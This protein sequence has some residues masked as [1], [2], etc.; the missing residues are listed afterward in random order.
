[1][2]ADDD[3]EDEEEDEEEEEENGYVGGPVDP[4]DPTM[5]EFERQFLNSLESHG[6]V[7]HHVSGTDPDFGQW[8]SGFLECLYPLFAPLNALIFDV[9]KRLHLESEYRDTLHV[10]TAQCDIKL[11]RASISLAVQ[12]C[13]YCFGIRKLTDAHC[14]ID[15]T[16]ALS[17]PAFSTK[18]N[19]WL[20]PELPRLIRHDFASFFVSRFLPQLQHLQK[21]S[22]DA[23]TTGALYRR[24]YYQVW[25]LLPPLLTSPLDLSKALALHDYSLCNLMAM[26]VNEAGTSSSTMDPVVVSEDSVAATVTTHGR[27]GGSSGI[28]GSGS[29]T[30]GTAY[31]Y[32]T[33]LPTICQ[34][35][36]SMCTSFS[37]TRQPEERAGDEEDLRV[38]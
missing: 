4:Q 32:Q 37:S 25:Q 19:A 38:R 13:F 23:S 15:L 30:A 11:Y 2:M 1:M 36:K 3:E 10:A 8:V 35:I 5:A 17:D 34:A 33:L 20:L 31:R 22:T 26:A 9:Y 12:G 16:V 27:G 29:S 6:C 7:N 28:G 21:L 14:P 24:L 18:S